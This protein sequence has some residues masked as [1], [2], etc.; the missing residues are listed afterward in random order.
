MTMRTLEICARLALGASAATVVGCND[1]SV[2][3]VATNPSLDQ[4]VRQAISPWG[5]VPVLPVTAPDPA[6]VDLGRALFFDKI[7]SG[8]RD[9]ACASCHDP[10][11]GTDDARSL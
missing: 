9:V 1:G 6:L 11:T 7:L 10:R 4:Q 2:T 3:P 8:N 5:V